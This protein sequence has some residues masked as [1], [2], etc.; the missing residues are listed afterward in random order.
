M[1]K[2]PSSHLSGLSKFLTV[3]IFLAMALGDRNRLH[4]PKG[5]RRHRFIKHRHNLNSHRCRLNFNDV[6][7]SCKGTLRRP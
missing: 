1:E 5:L 6:S 3:W 4:I 7:A 2:K